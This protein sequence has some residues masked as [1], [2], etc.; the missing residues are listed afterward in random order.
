[1]NTNIMF[2]H[3]SNLVLTFNFT[4]FSVTVFLNE[5]SLKETLVF[6]RGVLQT[7]TT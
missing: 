2:Y 3:L 6:T 7:N 4:G 1:M 5:T